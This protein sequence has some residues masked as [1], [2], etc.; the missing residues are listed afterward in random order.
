MIELVRPEREDVSLDVATGAGHTALKLAEHT[1]SVIAVDVTKEMLFQTRSGALEKELGNIAY[2]LE[3]VHHLSFKK[4]AFDIVTSRVAPHHFADIRTALREMCDVLKPGGKLYITDC[5]S[6][7]DEETGRLINEVERLRDGSHVYAYSEKQWREFIRELPL[8]IQH[9]HAGKRQYQL[10]E[11]FDR[12]NTPPENRREVFRILHNF[13]EESRA[14]YPFDD[15]SL[16]AYYIEML[17]TK[18]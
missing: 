4:N 11:W 18:I 14:L 15:D 7:D 12:M 10:Q 9:L 1:R 8:S 13:S 2:L 17:A 16:T 6:C 5:S 3:D